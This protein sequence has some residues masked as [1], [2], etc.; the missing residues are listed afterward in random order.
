MA[1]GMMGWFF[2]L[3]EGQVF[4]EKPNQPQPHDLRK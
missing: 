3:L 2:L 1:N 4:I